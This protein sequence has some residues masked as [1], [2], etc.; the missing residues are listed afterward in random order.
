MKDI[1]ITPKRIKT[2][3]KIWLVCFIAAVLINVISI[4]MY[5]T[6]WVEVFSQLHIVLLISLFVYILVGV[7]RLIIYAIA[8]FFKPL[9][10]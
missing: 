7:V 6:S 9:K 2:E 10:N 4:I 1:I 3:S 5:G 8:R